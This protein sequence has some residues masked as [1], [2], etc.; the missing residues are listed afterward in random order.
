MELGRR[1][2]KREIQGSS[3]GGGKTNGHVAL[4]KRASGKGGGGFTRAGMLFFISAEV[5]S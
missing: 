2:G 1:N 4:G 3:R 5:G